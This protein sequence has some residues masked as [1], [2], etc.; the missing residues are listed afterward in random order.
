ME[1]NFGGVYL[2]LVH[3]NKDPLNNRRLK[4]RVPQLFGSNSTDW[5]PA[6]LN[7]TTDYEAPK[8]N[9]TV[10]VMFEGGNPA[11][12]V[13][14]AVHAVPGQASKKVVIKNPTTSQLSEEFIVSSTASNRTELDL[15][16]TLVAMSQEIEDLIARVTSLEA[17]MT[18]EENKPDLT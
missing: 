16:A 12:P 4:V 5:A 3:D 14:S 1:Q 10:W 18:A 6:M 15:V 2:G 13:W 9:Q 7:N 11:F 17:R 8:V